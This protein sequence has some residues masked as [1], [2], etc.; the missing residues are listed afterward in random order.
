MD[1]FR[2]LIELFVFVVCMVLFVEYGWI[3]LLG[4][5]LYLLVKEM[6]KE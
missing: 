5:T 4:I 1:V 2:L 3:V 6:L